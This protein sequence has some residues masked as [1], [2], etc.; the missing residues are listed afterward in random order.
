MHEASE[1]VWGRGG[2]LPWIA[3]V[4]VLTGCFRDDGP[5]LCEGPGCTMVTSDGASSTSETS[6]TSPTSTDTSGTEGE[7]T[8][9]PIDTSITMRLNSMTFIDPHLFL[10]DLSDP[11]K[12]ICTDITL[13]VNQTLAEDLANDGF[14]LLVHLE[15]LTMAKEVRLIDADCTAAAMPG[16]L[17]QC[18]PNDATPAVVLG[19]DTVETPACSELDPTVYAPANVGLINAPLQPCMRTKRASFSLAISGSLGALD[20]RNAQFAASLDDPVAPTKLVNGVL[21]GF[22]T[23]LSAE[24][25]S[26][27]LPLLGERTL[28]SVIDVPECAAM[29]PDQLP[30]VDTLEINGMPAL[31]VWLAINFTGERVAYVTP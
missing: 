10:A 6:P 30:S 21:Y 5:Q 26:F 27:D 4:C 18:T 3:L 12:P 7:T 19:L 8:G 29:N 14:N 13:A 2:G 16:G 31:G 17:K 9:M 28:W 25:L 24:D 23:K 15:D 1:A 11:Q 22:F 20:L